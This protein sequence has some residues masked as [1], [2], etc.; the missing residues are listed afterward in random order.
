MSE[1]FHWSE[2]T[3]CY[4]RNVAANRHYF[5]NDAYLIALGCDEQIVTGN[6]NVS[7]VSFLTRLAMLRPRIDRSFVRINGRKSDG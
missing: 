2:T 7:G 5:G 3:G 1:L 4:V 6:V